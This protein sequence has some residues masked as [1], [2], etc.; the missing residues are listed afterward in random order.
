MSQKGFGAATQNQELYAWSF[1]LQT[2]DKFSIDMK[3]LCQRLCTCMPLIVYFVRV[4]IINLSVA[5][6]LVTFRRCCH[7]SSFVFFFVIKPNRKSISR[8]NFGGNSS[9]IRFGENYFLLIQN[10][11][12]SFHKTFQVTSFRLACDG[13]AAESCDE[14]SHK[15]DCEHFPFHVVD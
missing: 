5:R 3:Q 13:D 9:C 2:S 12:K 6:S 7:P 4:S 10:I 15:R 11:G 1:A 14:K 8:P